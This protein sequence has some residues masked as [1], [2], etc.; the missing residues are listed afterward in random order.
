MSGLFYFHAGICN[1]ADCERLGLGYAF[2]GPPTVTQMAAR[3]GP[4]GLS[5]T[6]LHNWPGPTLPA[7]LHWQKAGADLY[8]GYNP[9]KRPRPIDLR[10]RVGNEP[11]GVTAIRLA[12][13]Q[14]WQVPRVLPC[15]ERD[16]ERAIGLPLVYC[17]EAAAGQ[18]TAEGGRATAEGGCATGAAAVLQRVPERYD[19]LRKQCER[20]LAAYQGAGTHT[21]A[22]SQ[23]LELAAALLGVFYRVRLAELL[24]LELLSR[25]SVEVICMD[26]IDGFERELL[27]V[28]ADVA[29]QCDEAGFG[30]WAC[31]VALRGMAR[32]EGDEGAKGQR[33]KA[34]PQA[35]KGDDG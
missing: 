24:A 15:R 4:D 8:A 20:L 6:V 2:D 19:E 22:E 11:A 30:S 3:D 27:G 16:G 32:E 35:L 33:G 14:L 17:G 29:R 9:H 34:G 18:D 28:P 1:A 26:A 21:L 31:L 5:G 23:I 10:N 13:G 7:V 25:E 12:D